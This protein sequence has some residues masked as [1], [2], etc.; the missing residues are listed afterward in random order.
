MLK[1]NQRLK[2]I[3]LTRADHDSQD[4]NCLLLLIGFVAKDGGGNAEHISRVLRA[5]SRTKGLIEDATSRGLDG[6]RV[7]AVVVRN[8]GQE[9]DECFPD[10]FL[11]KM[12][13][14]V[15]MNGLNLQ[16]ADFSR[17]RFLYTKKYLQAANFQNSSLRS[18]LWR[19]ADLTCADFSG[20][21]LTGS[22]FGSMC[23][24]DGARFCGA[25]LE[26]CNIHLS[27]TSAVEGWSTVYKTATGIEIESLH[28]I[29]KPID[30]S[31]AT[32]DGAMM[33][34]TG[35]DSQCNLVVTGASLRKCV[36]KCDLK[37]LLT[38]FLSRLTSKQR[39]EIVLHETSENI[40][41]APWWKV[42]A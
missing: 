3:T 35:S 1:P 16:D 32:L 20:A 24:L 14:L 26:N 13:F 17:S 41:N 38:D 34:I 21:D 36:I 42:W 30:F 33:E 4:R 10:S 39:S 6:Q 25:K 2:A 29:T 31:N 15:N 5:L 11:D 7:W 9:W 40:L 18:T 27:F 23:S 12:Q 22:E 19:L 37:G 8:Q 28:G